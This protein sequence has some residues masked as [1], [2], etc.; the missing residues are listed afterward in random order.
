MMI[1]VFIGSTG[2]VLNAATVSMV[3]FARVMFVS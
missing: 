1:L 3:V 2:S